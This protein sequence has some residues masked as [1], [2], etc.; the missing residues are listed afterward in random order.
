MTDNTALA[1]E[2]GPWECFRDDSYY[3]M[4]C[5]RCVHDRTF[6]HGFHLVQGDEAA[7]LRDLLNTYTPA[8][9]PVGR[10]P[11]AYRFDHE[12]DGPDFGVHP[13]TDADK[14]AVWTETPLYASPQAQPTGRFP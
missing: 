14:A 10:A 3:D 12:W 8:P 9:A 7:A 1:Q 13:L 2:L 6:G 11:V 5:V 4:W